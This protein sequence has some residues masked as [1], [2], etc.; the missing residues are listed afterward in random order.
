MAG[1]GMT[2]ANKAV[3]LLAAP[4]GMNAALAELGRTAPVSL[5]EILPQQIRGQNVAADIVE[6]AGAV[7]YP[8]VHVYCEKI[9]NEMREKF[10]TFSGKVIMAAEVR[11]SQD[12]LEGLEGKLQLYVEAVMRVLDGNRGDWGSGMFYAGGYEVVFHPVKRGGK[13]FVQAAKVSFEVG[14]SD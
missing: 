4:P 3:A 5:P 14:V 11:I 2:V 8:A 6:R 12:Q 10:R 7:V 1:I 13:N 9:A